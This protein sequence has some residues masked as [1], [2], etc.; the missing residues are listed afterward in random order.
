MV[1]GVDTGG[2]FTD[3][4]Y[5]ERG[6]VGIYKTLSTPKN[7]AEAVLKGLDEFAGKGAKYLVHGST[8]ATNAVLE[9]KG[10]KTAL[11]TN[12]GFED[13]IEI[14]RQ[15][16]EKLYDLK[17][18]KPSPLVAESLR[19]GI[20]GRIFYTGVVRE[21]IDL[22]E[23][24]ELIDVVAGRGAESVAVSL[25]FSYANPSHEKEVE[26][27]LSARGLSVSASHKILP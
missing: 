20:K 15:S 14:G 11:I 21:D 10:V 17:Y 6:R 7:P 1:I 3:F 16:R 19:F 26:N 23:I 8:V 13:I 27:L 12:R 24:K 2:T 18:V 9:R 5:I 22:G 4:V 25:L